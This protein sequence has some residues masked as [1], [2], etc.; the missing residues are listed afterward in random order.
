VDTMEEVCGEIDRQLLCLETE[1]GKP[2]KLQE[3]DIVC[4]YPKNGT[5]GFVR[6]LQMSGMGRLLFQHGGSDDKCY[7]GDVLKDKSMRT[8]L[9]SHFAT[10]YGFA[11][12]NVSNNEEE[13]EEGGYVQL[14]QLLSP[15]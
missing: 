5:I 10:E 14:Y 2:T 7:I 15:S 13:D 9:L 6:T 11:L 4:I 8:I 3:G 12:E 1:G